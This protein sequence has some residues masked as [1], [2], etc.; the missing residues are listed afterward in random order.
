MC[1]EI[2]VD[3]SR[4]GRA[5]QGAYGWMRE[6]RSS[7]NAANPAT[8]TGKI[9][10]GR[11]K[12]LEAI[13][14]MGR[15][16]SRRAGKQYA[17]KRKRTIKVRVK[18]TT[19]KRDGKI[20]HRKAYTY[21][22]E[23]LGKPG[24]GPKVIPIEKGKLS[25]FGYSTKKS[26]RARH[27]ALNKAVEKYGA[28]SVARMLQAQIILRKRTQPHVRSIFEEDLEWLKSNYKQDGYLS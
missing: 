6:R 10:G 4:N 19:Y 13:W 9:I 21:E 28:L 25:Q 12:N 3:D 26:E 22:R 16:Y 24:K 17:R 27:A 23:D 15:S 5:Y 8:A 7:R 20:I 1:R 14:K 11:S 2:V 18:A